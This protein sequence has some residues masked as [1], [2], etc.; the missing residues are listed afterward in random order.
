MWVYIFK[1]WKDWFLY[2]ASQRETGTNMINLIRDSDENWYKEEI[3]IEKRN[4]ILETKW[5]IWSDQRMIEEFD[6]EYKIFF[7]LK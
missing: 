1:K 4:F 5:L 3:D 7:D 6:K 2:P